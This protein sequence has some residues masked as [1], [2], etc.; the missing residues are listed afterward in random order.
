[1]L[2][3]VGFLHFCLAPFARCSP[4]FQQNVTGISPDVH[5]NSPEIH[6]MFSE[7]RQSIAL[8]QLKKGDYHNSARPQLRGVFLKRMKCPARCSEGRRPL[9]AG[10]RGLQRLVVRLI[11][12]LPRGKQ[13]A[14]L[15]VVRVRIL[16]PGDANKEGGICLR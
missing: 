7:F 9:I 8:E 5:Q 1:M 2:L 4:Q 12:D 15:R 16:I 6:R 14:N 11:P 13:T 3:F 10:R